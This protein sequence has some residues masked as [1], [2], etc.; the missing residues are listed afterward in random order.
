MFA[1]KMGTSATG[2]TI[3]IWVHN[4]EHNILPDL[5]DSKKEGGGACN[6]KVIFLSFTVLYFQEY[7]WKWGFSVLELYFQEYQW[8]WGFS[9]LEKFK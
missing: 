5:T 3:V 1:V 7:Q 8:N 6:K 4:D 9:V 2:A